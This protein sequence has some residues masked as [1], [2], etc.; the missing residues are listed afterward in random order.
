MSCSPNISPLLCMHPV[1]R[2]SSFGKATRYGLDGSAIE[3]RWG[4]RFSTPVQTGPGFH[5]ASCTM[6]TDSFPGVE[7][8][9]RGVDHLPYLAQRLKKEKS[10]TTTSPCAF[11][12]CS[13]VKYTCLHPASKLTFLYLSDKLCDTPNTTIFL[14]TSGG[15]AE[16]VT[17]RVEICNELCF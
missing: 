14:Q 5:P 4:A 2:E 17:S 1:G 6:G 8:P 11:V 9:G 10:Y 12:A 13:R 15:P 7:R 3:S 16:K